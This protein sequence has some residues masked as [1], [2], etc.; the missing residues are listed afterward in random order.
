MK[1]SCSKSY[2]LQSV[3]YQHLWYILYSKYFISYFEYYFRAAPC[4]LPLANSFCT[5]YKVMF[6]SPEVSERDFIICNRLFTMIAS[7]LKTI[8]I[9]TNFTQFN[10]YHTIICGIF[11]IVNSL[12]AFFNSNFVGYPVHCHLKT[13]FGWHRTLHYCLSVLQLVK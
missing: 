11:C 1:T 8:S 6:E 2:I 3:F 4:I 10:R 9:L 5:S 7:I 13:R 12:W